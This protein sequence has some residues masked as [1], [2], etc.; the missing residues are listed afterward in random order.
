[1]VCIIVS[2]ELT[3]WLSLLGSCDVDDLILNLVG[4]TLGF[5]VWSIINKRTDC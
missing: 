2:I 3:Q 4:T 1:M 5:A